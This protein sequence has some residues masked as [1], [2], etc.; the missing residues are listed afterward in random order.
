[1]T[2]TLLFELRQARRIRS[3]FQ[4][5]NPAE[6]IQNTKRFVLMK[7]KVKCKGG[8]NISNQDT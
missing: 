1:M 5:Q 4:R 8:H 2:N 6:Y 7:L 3:H